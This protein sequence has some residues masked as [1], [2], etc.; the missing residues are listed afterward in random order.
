MTSLVNAERVSIVGGGITGASLAYR[1]SE[2]ALDVSLYERGELGEGAT[3]AS[4]AVF[5]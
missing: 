4:M 2:T 3:A 5:A 1:L